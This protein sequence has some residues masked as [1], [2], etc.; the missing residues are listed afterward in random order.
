MND[1]M[2]F[3]RQLDES[4]RQDIK[5]LFNAFREY[6]TLYADTIE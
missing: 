4:E 5:D 3:L 1:F 6:H 2:D